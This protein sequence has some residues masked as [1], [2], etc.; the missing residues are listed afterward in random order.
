[1]LYYLVPYESAGSRQIC[2]VKPNPDAIALV[3]KL[4]DQEQPKQYY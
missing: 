2:K 3:V 4:L 1:M